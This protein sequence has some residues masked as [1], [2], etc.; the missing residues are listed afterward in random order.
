M[1]KFH[2][3][4]TLARNVK[5]SDVEATLTLVVLASGKDKSDRKVLKS[6]RASCRYWLSK[7][8]KTAARVE[9]SKVK[10]FA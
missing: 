1:K 7:F 9:H 5:R 6:L 3:I 8:E 2:G 10:A 4:D